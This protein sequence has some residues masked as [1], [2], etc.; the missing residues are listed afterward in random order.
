MSSWAN[1]VSA[2][3]DP[4]CSNPLGCPRRPLGH[5]GGVE[6]V[7]TQCGEVVRD[8]PLHLCQLPRQCRQATQ[9]AAVPLLLNRWFRIPLFIGHGIDDAAGAG[10]HI[11][12]G[13]QPVESRPGG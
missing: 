9:L 4:T 13:Q 5:R 11:Y 6:P 2:C 7:V 3:S 1:A 12:V 10:P 8:L